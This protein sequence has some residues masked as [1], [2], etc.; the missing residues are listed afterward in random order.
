M[1]QIQTNHKVS[2]FL[3]SLGCL[4][5]SFSPRKL[6]LKAKISQYFCQS[7]F[8]GFQKL[9][10]TPQYI[11][12][13]WMRT[14]KK[15]RQQIL[16]TTWQGLNNSK[17]TIHGRK[18][19]PFIIYNVWYCWYYRYPAIWRES[20]YRPPALCQTKTYT[21]RHLPTAKPFCHTKKH[22]AIYWRPH[23]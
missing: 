12:L 15:H 10:E 11:I 6:G 4:W 16:P 5:A 7:R 14:Q 23:T 8:K 22:I 21:N 19:P 1:T 3:N 13:R 20:K 17:V 9:T 2:T 18:F